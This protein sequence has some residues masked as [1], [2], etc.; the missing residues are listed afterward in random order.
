LG[1]AKTRYIKEHY[2]EVKLRRE[3]YEELRK[4][5]E[6]RGLSIPE[7]IRE[8]YKHY[9]STTSQGQAQPTTPSTQ[10]SPNPSID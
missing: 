5:A 9:I 3:F 2:R 7:L 10:S 8:L 1:K 6:S 4:L